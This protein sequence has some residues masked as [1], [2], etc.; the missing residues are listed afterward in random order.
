MSSTLLR[1]APVR[2]TVATLA[3]VISLSDGAA[4]Q[5]PRFQL[6]LEAG[7]AWI[8][9]ND[10]QI[11]NNTSATRFSLNDVTG[12]GPWPAGRVYL[13]WNVN[14][15]HGLRLLAAPLSISETGTLPGAVRFAGGEYSGSAPVRATYAFNSYRLTYRYQFRD[16]EQTHLWVGF[17]GKIR[18]ATVKLEQGAVATRKDDFGFVPLLHVAGDWRV[19]SRWR[20]G[21]DIDALAGGPGRAIDAAVKLGYTLGDRVSLHGGYRTVEGGADVDDVYSFAWV[22]YAVASVVWR[23]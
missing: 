1:C 6:E 15:R 9:R 8:S 3:M 10:A 17:T 13:T 16:T 12:S 21:T 14:E 5:A 18:D 20:F 19:A 11:P 23:W 22:H 4:A 2:Q 7:P